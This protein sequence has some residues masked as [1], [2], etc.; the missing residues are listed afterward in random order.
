MFE[1]RFDIDNLKFVLYLYLEWNVKL[2]SQKINV[3]ICW[4]NVVIK[5]IRKANKINSLAFT[6][7]Y[8][9]KVFEYI[10]SSN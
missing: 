1:C 2:Y 3:K 8:S 5:S 9:V 6:E 7:V 4:F 10:S